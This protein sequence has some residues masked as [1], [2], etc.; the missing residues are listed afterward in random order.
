M[1]VFRKLFSVVGMLN[2]SFG[3]DQLGCVSLQGEYNQ[4]S[5]DAGGK[6]NHQVFHTGSLFI[7]TSHEVNV[8]KVLAG[9]FRKEQ[10]LNL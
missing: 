7:H 5:Y 6:I 9:Y 10:A 2:C 1:S 4:H 3:P 8:E